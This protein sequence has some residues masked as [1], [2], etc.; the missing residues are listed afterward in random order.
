MDL[1]R[2]SFIW[3]VHSAHF[4]LY[5]FSNLCCYLTFYIY[6]LFSQM[7]PNP[8]DVCGSFFPPVCLS[9]RCAFSI[10]DEHDDDNG[11]GRASCPALPPSLYLLSIPTTPTKWLKNSWMLQPHVTFTLG[12]MW[13]CWQFLPSSQICSP[14]LLWC[15]FLVLL[16]S[17]CTCKFSYTLG[18]P[19]WSGPH[20]LMIKAKLLNGVHKAIYDLL[21]V[22]LFGPISHHCHLILWPQTPCTT[23]G[24]QYVLP[25]HLACWIPIH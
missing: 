21:T 8:Q 17:L 25:L 1:S 4:T 13:H 10:D 5:M 15:V 11:G 24:S 20:Y 6:G 19:M 14:W 23:F 7:R 16:Q 2:S 9:G 3:L 12:N 22:H 18:I